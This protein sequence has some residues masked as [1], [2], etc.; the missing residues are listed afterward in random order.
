MKLFQKNLNKEILYVAE[1]GVNHGGNFKLFKKLIKDAKESGVDVV[2]FQCFTPDLYIS[3][4]EKKYERLK[5]IY[6]NRNQFNEII[7]YC[8]K[9]NINYLFTPVSHDWLNYIKSKSSYIKIASG[10]LNFKPLLEKVV[11]H[12][13]NIILSTGVSN[14]QEIRDA[15]KIFKKKYK[16]NYKNKLILMHCVSNYPVEDSDANILSVRCLSDK[17]KLTTGYSNHVIGINA[18]LAAICNGARVIEFHFTDNKKRRFR[19]H[20]LSLDKKDVK[21]LIKIGNN[22]NLLLGKYEKKINSKL[23]NSRKTLMKGLIANQDLEK[24]DFIKNNDINFA[25]PAKFFYS[26]DKK[27]ILGKKIKSDLKKG[28]LFKKKHFK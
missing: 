23:L 6:F 27:K 25:R 21:N 16:S 22:L 10:D 3:R 9:I 19:D 28:S 4:D 5:K 18:C 8:K 26:Y 24:G 17:F 14:E 11:K 20:Q 13:F 2:K 12:K 1:L 15:L 7:N